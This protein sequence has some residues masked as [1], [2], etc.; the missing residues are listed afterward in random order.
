MGRAARNEARWMYGSSREFAELLALARL[1]LLGQHQAPFT[2]R[3][4][5][6]CLMF[7]LSWPGTAVAHRPAVGLPWRSPAAARE[8][9]LVG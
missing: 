2:W 4:Y 5:R 6:F 8:A 3:S 1:G 7:R 9:P